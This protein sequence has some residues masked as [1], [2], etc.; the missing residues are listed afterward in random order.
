MTS[1]TIFDRR[2]LADLDAMHSY[3]SERAGSDVADNYQERLIARCRSAG[4]APLTGSPRDDL[5]PG[6]RTIPFERR[7]TI[8]Y[9][10]DGD[11]VT[12]LQVIHAGRDIAAA[13]T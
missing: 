1:N 11:R 10:V 8:A 3:I 6:L 13:F 2:A 5:A 12:I 9:T 7:A 4:I